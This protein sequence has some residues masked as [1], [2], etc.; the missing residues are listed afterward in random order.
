[1][2]IKSYLMDRQQ[3]VG[4]DGTDSS[5]LQVV[6]G[7]PQGSVLGLLLF[8]NYINNVATTIDPDSKINNYG[9]RIKH[10]YFNGLLSLTTVCIHIESCLWT[11]VTIPISP[12]FNSENFNLLVYYY[13]IV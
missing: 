2:W 10:C 13:D 8:I 9:W 7:V 3:Y 5:M 4:I 1:M 11:F 12:F 6:S